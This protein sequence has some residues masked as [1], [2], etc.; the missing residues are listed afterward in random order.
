MAE[1]PVMSLGVLSLP[2][3]GRLFRERRAELLSLAGAIDE[4]DRPRLAVYLRGGTHIFAFMEWT[5]DVLG[6]AFHTP[7]GSGIRSDGTYYWRGD[8]ADYV[9]HY[10]IALPAEFV[11]HARNLD[12]QAGPLSHE[13]MIEVND[14]LEI[15]FHVRVERP[16]APGAE[17]RAGGAGSH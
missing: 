16:A 4:A 3:V 5:R 12:W 10:G 11:E 15:E 1:P 13:R 7:G 17:G 9:E 2:E 6:D 8:A 14:E